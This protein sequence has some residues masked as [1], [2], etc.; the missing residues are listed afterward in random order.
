VG[1][2]KKTELLAIAGRDF[3]KE[4]IINA[5]RSQGPGGQNVNKVNTKIEI[6]FQPSSSQLLTDTEKE[7]LA[8][9]L[10]KKLTDNGFLIITSQAGRSQL[11]NK[12][13][14]TDKFYR[15]LNR[16]LTTRKERKPTKRT[17]KSTEKRLEGKRIRADQKV[18]RKK[19]DW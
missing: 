19:P 16:A 17:A 11:K 13:T 14:A 15:I 10:K 3:S 6:R 4:W 12:Q 1:R 2:T 9:S 18:L 5:S 8:K 7:L